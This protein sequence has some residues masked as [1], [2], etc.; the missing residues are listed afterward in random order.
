MHEPVKNPSAKWASAVEQG[1]DAQDLVQRC[2]R[3][4]VVHGGEEV[5]LLEG[6]AARVPLEQGDVVGEEFVERH[7]ALVAERVADDGVEREAPGRRLLD[8]APASQR[9]Q[10]PTRR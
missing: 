8:E 4:R 7:A 9:L 10:G 6:E 2:R 1:F 5:R 3:L